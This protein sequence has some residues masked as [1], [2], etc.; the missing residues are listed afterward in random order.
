ML[1]SIL[2]PFKWL[3]SLPDESNTKVRGKMMHS[4]IKPSPQPMVNVRMPKPNAKIIDTYNEMTAY[5]NESKDKSKFK[6]VGNGAKQELWIPHRITQEHKEHI[7]ASCGFTKD[8]VINGERVYAPQLIHVI[9]YAMN[10]YCVE[11]GRVVSEITDKASKDME[12]L[13]KKRS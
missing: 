9:N 13:E 3:F 8:V 4:H 1:K 2:K 10:M 12:N 7:L 11:V 6:D 5:H